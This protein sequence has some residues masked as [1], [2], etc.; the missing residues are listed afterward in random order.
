MVFAVV[1]VCSILFGIL[2]LIKKY[3]GTFSATLVGLVLVSLFLVLVPLFLVAL[4]YLLGFAILVGG[5]ALMCGLNFVKYKHW[6]RLDGFKK[7]VEIKR[8][9][10]RRDTDILPIVSRKPYRLD[11]THIWG[12][13]HFY[14][15]DQCTVCGVQCKNGK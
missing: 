8:E 3:I 10:E 14:Y 4:P 6:Y 9:D 5:V 13:A 7:K 11:H 2:S 15:L 1:I 12:P